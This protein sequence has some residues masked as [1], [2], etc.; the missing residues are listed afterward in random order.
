MRSCDACVC[1]CQ[2]GPCFELSL[3]KSELDEIVGIPR[4]ENTPFNHFNMV[5]SF[6]FIY[7]PS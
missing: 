7:F 6:E 3:L 4:K 5:F 1:V 2:C